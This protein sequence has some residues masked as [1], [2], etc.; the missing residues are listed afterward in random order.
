MVVAKVSP[1]LV[2]FVFVAVTGTI[3]IL[4]GSGSGENSNLQDT[5]KTCA[6]IQ[7]KKLL[8]KIASS[9][10]SC[11]FYFLSSLD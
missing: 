5:L 4:F 6:S 11:D 9:I 8:G 10:S 3:I 2:W 1:F 7:A